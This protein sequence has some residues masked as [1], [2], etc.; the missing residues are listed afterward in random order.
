MDFSEL[1]SR[2]LEKMNMVDAERNERREAVEKFRMVIGTL[3]DKDD[4]YAYVKRKQTKPK[5]MPFRIVYTR[6]FMLRCSSSPYATLPP[7]NMPGIVMEMPDIV[8]KFP[9]RFLR[10]A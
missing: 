6:D 2:Q 5:E 10:T 9:R 8:A 1:I 4:G 3:L 7:K